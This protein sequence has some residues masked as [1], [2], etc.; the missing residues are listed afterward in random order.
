MLTQRSEAVYD[1]DSLYAT[2]W[3][4]MVRLAVLLVD[5]AASAE[6]VVQDAFVALHR[7]PPRHPD[8]AVA[9]LRRCVV[10]GARSVLRKREVSRR[11]AAESVQAVEPGADAPV[12]VAA[13][14]AELMTALRR[15]APRQREVLVLRYWS[16]LSEAQIAQALG[17]T[18]GTV[19]STASRALDALE[20]MLGGGR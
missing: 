8:A 14:H 11:R 2:Q 6:D 4:P 3:A 18:K 19:K 5:N 9:Y 7:R 15:L 10:N 1:I 17:I 12:L 20:A 16:E 13:E